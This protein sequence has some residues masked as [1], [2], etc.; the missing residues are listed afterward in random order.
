MVLGPCAF[1]VVNL[2]F[3]DFLCLL[4]HSGHFNNGTDVDVIK[5]KVVHDTA[6]PLF[7]IRQIIFWL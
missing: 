3:P 4:C 7:E 1:I 2:A 6:V 5:P